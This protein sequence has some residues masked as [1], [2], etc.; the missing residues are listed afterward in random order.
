M[1]YSLFIH[2]LLRNT[3]EQSQPPVIPA[4]AGISAL[5]CLAHVGTEVIAI[6]V[7]RTRF[8]RQEPRGMHSQAGAWEREKPDNSQLVV[9]SQVFLSFFLRGFGGTFSFV[10]KSTPDKIYINN[11]YAQVMA[12]CFCVI[13]HC[14]RN[15]T[16]LVRPSWLDMRLSSCSMETGPS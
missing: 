16:A 15:S 5:T 9:R 3:L 1:Y 6:P 12:L 8:P 13:T 11:I 4:E 7:E 14:F 2:P 10:R